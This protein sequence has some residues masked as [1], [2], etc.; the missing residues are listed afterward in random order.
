M[1][2][3]WRGA[4]RGTVFLPLLYL[5]TAISASAATTRPNAIDLRVDALPARV[6]LARSAAALVDP[7]RQVAATRLVHWYLPGWFLSVLLPVVGRA[8]FWQSGSAARLRDALRQRIR[9]EWPVRFL[10]GA[11]LGAV[12]RLSS[13]LPELYIYRVHRAMSLSDQLLRAW[14]ADWLFGSIVTMIALGLVIAI[15]LGLADR[16]H[17][18]YLYTIAGIFGACFAFAYIAPFIAIPAFDRVV[19]LPSAAAVV[20]RRAERE[21]GMAIPIFE[22][23]RKRTHLG[24]AYVIGF[25]A[26]ERIMIG[27]AVFEVAS[28]AELRYAI[29]RQLGFAADA[30]TLKIALADALLLVFSVAI[31]VAVADRFPFRRDD[32]P[33]SRIALVGALLGVLYLIAVPI[34]NAVLRAIAS[35]ADAYAL[36]LPVDRAAAVRSVIRSTDQ[37]LEEVCPD[38][39]A[40]L[41]VQRGVDASS[42]VSAINGVPSTCP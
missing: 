37:R 40:R 11:A 17:Q 34:D 8:Y 26:T 4:L 29:A 7:D 2:R 41:F 21:A 36:A 5:A 23:M 42:R 38:V 22:Q 31:A 14:G 28:P 3:R 18:W 16:T 10:F 13:L 24:A 25:G 20:A 15:V 19:P 12:V 33:V 9:G 35:R 1:I 30:S 32:D 6:L 27:D 39:M